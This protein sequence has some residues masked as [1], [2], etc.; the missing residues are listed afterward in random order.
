MPREILCPLPLVQDIRWNFNMKK[1]IL[2]LSI[3]LI[4]SCDLPFDPGPMPS[5]IVKTE[6]EPGLN[7]FG[8]LRVDGKNYGTS[9]VRVERAYEL[10]E[11]ELEQAF[12]PTIDSAH[13][14]IIHP[15]K[16]TTQ[17]SFQY[18]GRY[19]N[20]NFIPTSGESYSIRIDS[21]DFPIVSGQTTVPNP[22]IIV[23]DRSNASELGL[24]ITPDSTI[25]LMEI[26]PVY[27]M[28]IDYTQRYT[29]KNEL[30]QISVP[31]NHEEYG[32]LNRIELFSYDK[33]MSD[34]LQA[35][36]TV[37]PQAYNE[38]V[39]TVEGGYGVFGSVVKSEVYK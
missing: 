38:M 31:V 36:V 11:I 16:D 20:E 30:I 3:L 15:Q 6:F 34:Y 1:L 22:P 21:T 10:N 32:P 8:I 35:L 18:N 37:K 7:I 14:E 29:N 2:I 39:K 17:F 23:E 26:Y 5:D 12:V 25:H 33:N 13:V 4:P 28:G 24:K 19:D 27:G 9:F